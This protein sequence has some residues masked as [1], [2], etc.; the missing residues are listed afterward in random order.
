MTKVAEAP[1]GGGGDVTLLRRPPLVTAAIVSM[2]LVIVA[3]TVLVA[4][5]LL[6][7]AVGLTLAARATSRPSADRAATIVSIGFGLA[8]GPAV[9]LLLALVVAVAG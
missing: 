8:V 7:G 4:T 2:I 5:A 6:A 9:Y 3:L 1:A